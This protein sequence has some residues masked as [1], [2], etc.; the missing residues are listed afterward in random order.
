MDG[1][2]LARM[3]GRAVRR[4]AGRA[5]LAARKEDVP[6]LVVIEVPGGS[7]ALDEALTDAW[8]L[9]DHPP[10]GNRLRM[11]GPID[12]GW[13]VASLWDSLEQFQA[14]LEERLHITLDDAGGD[15]P[16]ITFW[17]IEKVD[18]FD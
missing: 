11:S 18:R 13:R 9:T 1:R 14:F 12:G 7:S 6:V 3:L 2:P 17:E 16:T 8:N 4:G 15:A 5:A 10:A